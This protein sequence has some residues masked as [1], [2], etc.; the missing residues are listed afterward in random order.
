MKA[1][2]HPFPKA[3]IAAARRRLFDAGLTH[4]Q[5]ADAHKVS[6]QIVR[7]VLSGQNNG[8]RGLGHRVA[9]LLKLKQDRKI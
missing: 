5:F 4:Q 6:I 2:K 1:T 3:D 9:V 7:A 8:T